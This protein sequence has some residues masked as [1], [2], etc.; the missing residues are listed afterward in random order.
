LNLAFLKDF[1]EFGKNKRPITY[2]WHQRDLGNSYKSSDTYGSTENLKVTGSDGAIRISW[3]FR[4]S[5]LMCGTTGINPNVVPA[6]NRIILGCS[7]AS[8]EPYGITGNRRDFVN[9]QPFSD[10]GG[11]TEEQR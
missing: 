4:I 6:L 5:A 8:L 3:D 1:S 11:R 9:S 10:G 7:G 2:H